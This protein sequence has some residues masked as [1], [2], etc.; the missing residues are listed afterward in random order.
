M[1]RSYG[2]SDAAIGT[3]LKVLFG[4]LGKISHPCSVIAKC[5]PPSL[6]IH[7]PSLHLL[8]ML[9]QKNQN[10]FADMLFAKNVTCDSVYKFEECKEVWNAS[11]YTYDI[12]IIPRSE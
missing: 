11:I 10:N 3:L 4:V 8:Y 9:Q 2:L 7:P 12:P 1:R 6:Y 5:L